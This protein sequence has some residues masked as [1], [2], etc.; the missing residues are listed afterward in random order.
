VMRA[1]PLFCRAKQATAWVEAGRSR[2][3]SN[4]GFRHQL[5][6]YYPRGLEQY[7]GSGHVQLEKSAITHDWEDAIREGPDTDT[8]QAIPSH[9]SLELG[10][11]HGR[12][13]W[14]WFWLWKTGLDP[15]WCILA[16]RLSSHC[17]V[18]LPTIYLLGAT[19]D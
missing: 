6:T 18:C 15:C 2:S 19:R 10:H 17:S 1:G 13:C 7:S 14:H 11:N 4:A 3:L 8:R 9:G 12:G 16:D 5:I